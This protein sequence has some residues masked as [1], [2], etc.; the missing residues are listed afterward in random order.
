MRAY[1]SRP[2]IRVRAKHAR[3]SPLAGQTSI[4]LTH[5]SPRRPHENRGGE[6]G[7]GW[8]YLLH[9]LL[10]PR[11]CEL[12]RHGAQLLGA[13]GLEGGRSHFIGAAHLKRDLEVAGHRSADPH[14]ASGPVFDLGEVEAVHEG[15]GRVLGA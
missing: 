12:R 15:Q 2:G 11:G 9:A 7:P 13:V 3:P 1:R 5:S 4:S 10:G 6:R 8:G 14:G